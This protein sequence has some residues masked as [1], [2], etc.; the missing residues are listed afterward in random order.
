MDSRFR[1]GVRLLVVAAAAVLLSHVIW[2][3][4]VQTDGTT[5]KAS[6][7][8]NL[9]QLGKAISMFAMDHGGTICPL[10]GRVA[11]QSWEGKDN[12][13]KLKDAYAPY[14]QDPNIWYCPADPYAKSHTLPAPDFKPPADQPDM[15]YD[16]YY[17]SYRHYDSI[18]QE[19]SPAQLDAVCAVRGTKAAALPGGVWVATPDMIML[20]MDDGCFH[21]PPVSGEF[22]KVY[23][24]NVL[25]RDGHVAFETEETMR[26]P[27]Q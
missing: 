2:A 16:H 9:M 12:A 19:T 5:Q 6:C 27:K 11:R 4:S 15:L 13:Q 17:M 21:G 20:M 25:F 3:Q 23:G 10:R 1:T 26:R 18:E 14:I 22:G 24:R 8:Y 7:A